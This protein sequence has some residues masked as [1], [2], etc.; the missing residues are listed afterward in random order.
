MKGT[1]GRGLGVPG[2]QLEVPCATAASR[3]GSSSFEGQRV[4]LDVDGK[5]KRRV[6]PVSKDPGADQ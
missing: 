2:R 1:D 3:G 5:P 6:G 4:A